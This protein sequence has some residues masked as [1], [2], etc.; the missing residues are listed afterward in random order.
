[1]ASKNKIIS[2]LI[3]FIVISIFLSCD[4][5]ESISPSHKV[6]NYIKN[7]TQE[8]IIVSSYAL[9]WNSD[10]LKLI[11]RDSTIKFKITE[12]EEGT[13]SDYF[14]MSHI[15]K[16]DSNIFLY[17]YSKD[18]VLLKTWNRYYTDETQKQFFRESDWVKNYYEKGRYKYHEYTFT[19]NQEDIN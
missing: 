17:V 10:S 13:T 14:F 6:I 2:I 19:I 12:I 9:F 7:N 16:E 18:T 15:E 4:P 11:K 5:L 1:M 3:G 8:D